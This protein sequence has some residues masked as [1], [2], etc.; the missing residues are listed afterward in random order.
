MRD[1]AMWVFLINPVSFSFLSYLLM[2]LFFTALD[3]HHPHRPF[4]SYAHILVATYIALVRSSHTA[5]RCMPAQ[6]YARCNASQLR[7]CASQ[8]A[9]VC[10]CSCQQAG[11]L[12][13]A[14]DCL[15]LAKGS[16]HCL[17][18]LWSTVWMVRCGAGAHAGPACVAGRAL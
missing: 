1:K 13:C 6:G 7:A 12:H 10:C 14:Q 3:E 8:R 9:Q 2:S 15:D 16:W 4:F 17:A 11:T 5:L 18:L